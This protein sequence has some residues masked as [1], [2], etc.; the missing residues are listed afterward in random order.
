VNEFKTYKEVNSLLGEFL[1]GFSHFENKDLFLKHPTNLDISYSD[2]K[3]IQYYYQSVKQGVLT[4]KQRLDLLIKEKLWEEEKDER[5]EN[6]KLQLNNLKQTKSKLFLSKQIKEISDNISNLEKEYNNIRLEKEE[7]MGE[8]AETYAIKKS[9]EYFVL[10]LFY[11]DEQFKECVVNKKNIEEIFLDDTEELFVYYNI[12][13]R[14]FNKNI[15]K[16]AALPSL[17]NAIF[18]FE[19]GVIDFFGKEVL[20]LTIYQ[21]EVLS[22]LKNYKNILIK[23]N[24]FPSEDLYEDF[25]RLVVWYESAG[26]SINN[27]NKETKSSVKQKENSGG[28]Y[29]GATKEE[30]ERLAKNKGEVTVDL[31]KE[32]AKKGGELSFQDILKLHQ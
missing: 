2:Q 21:S 12:T 25:D 4:N 30:L 7:L 3:Y 26:F 5:I 29:I 16:I 15:K 22:K 8:T 27:E 18:L 1:Q 20:K 13:S 10:S 31:T 23:T 32:A 24:N 11:K 17:I 9:N 28:S 14:K 6:L 19:D